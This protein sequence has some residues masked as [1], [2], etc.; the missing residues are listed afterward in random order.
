MFSARPR[1]YRVA[2]KENLLYGR[3]P[4]L[5]ERRLFPGILPPLLALVGLLLVPPGVPLVAYL[6]GLAAAFELSLGSNGYLYP[7]LYEHA[8]PFRGLRAPARAAV[9]VLLFLGVLAAH[10]YAALVRAAR[11]RVRQAAAAAAIAVLLLEYWVAPLPLARYANTPPPLYAWLAAQPKGLVAEFPMPLPNT[12]P[13]H[14]PRYVY[15][16]TFHWL[17]L[18]N[19]Y[20]GY[21]PRSY[22]RRLDRLAGFPDDAS[23]EVLRSAGVRYVV[24]HSSGYTAEERQRVISA[25][26][27]ERRLAHVADYYDGW[28]EGAVFILR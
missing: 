11:P 18:L 23:M 26:A 21:Y 8:P 12:L 22:I 25:A 19:G 27:R 20:S 17:P 3:W 24:V 7:L 1:D 5:P 16:S 13:G 14:D 15:M 2:T 4:G 6:I 9:F 28:G 10:G